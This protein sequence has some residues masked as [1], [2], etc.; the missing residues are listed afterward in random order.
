ME[1]LLIKGAKFVESSMKSQGFGSDL[2]AGER[3]QHERVHVP[4]HASP[5]VRH[6][7]SSAAAA[8]P[9]DLLPLMHPSS[10]AV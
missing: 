4:L 10:A 7:L 5:S 8:D 3:M 9:A 6:H 2:D 1:I